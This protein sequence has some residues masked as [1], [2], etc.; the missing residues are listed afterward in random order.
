[1]NTIETLIDSVHT[2]NSA[3]AQS[4]ERSDIQ[5]RTPAALA[6]SADPRTSPTYTFLSSEN[7]IQAL[8]NA[9]FVPVAAAQTRSRRANPLSARH[10]I[11]FRRRYETVS[12]RDCIPEILFLNA[13]D[14]RM[15]TQFRLALF[16]PV[17]TNGLVVCDE[18]LPVWRVPH[19]G[20]TLDEVIA[21]AIRQSEQFAEV[22]AWVER[23]ERTRL[24]AEQRVAFATCAISLRFP[25]KQPEGLDPAQL[26]RPRREEDQGNDL[27]TTYNVVQEHVI[28]GGLSYQTGKNRKMH[29][30]G[31]RAIREDVR[32]N[33]ELWRMAT[34]LAA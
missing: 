23:M 18:T 8:G 7:V 26:L 2:P 3:F 11:R 25:N 13:H 28:K 6:S 1:M 10:A 16:R 30:R 22:G 5:V 9:G 20:N 29:S 17:C 21:A 4:L 12:L 34:A 14:G 32:L 27:W 31:I 19:R 24:E 33:S 15:A